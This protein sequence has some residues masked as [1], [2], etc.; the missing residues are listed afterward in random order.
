MAAPRTEDRISFVDTTESPPG[1]K[2]SRSGDKTSA[3]GDQ[4]HP[5]G[6]EQGGL[7]GIL[8]ELKEYLGKICEHLPLNDWEKRRPGGKRSRQKSCSEQSTSSE[9]DAA[10]DEPPAKRTYLNTERERDAISVTASN[11]DVRHFL[12]DTLGQTSD[13]VANVD[14]EDELLKQLEAA[15]KDED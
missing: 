1:D 14:S 3:P 6:N 15:L 5:R 12:Q 7:T 13:N 11:K 8:Q 2:T 10:A 9:E 4:I